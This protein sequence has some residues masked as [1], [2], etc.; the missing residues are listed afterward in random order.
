MSKDAGL[1]ARVFARVLNSALYDADCSQKARELLAAGDVHGAIGEWRR[2][3]ELGSGGARCVLAYLYLRGAPSIPID[4]EEARR[5]CL[6]ALTSEPGYAN[7]LL[8]CLSRMDTET[9]IKVKYLLASYKAGFV[10]AE[11]MMAGIMMASA[12]EPGTRRKKAETMLRRAIDA[13]HVPALIL[14]SSF[15]RAGRLGLVKRVLGILLFPVSQ[16]TYVLTIRFR[17]FSVSSFT[18][19]NE[20][21]RRLFADKFYDR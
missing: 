9:S 5:L 18:Y 16:I 13:G 3:A 15:Y 21:T 4:V 1:S 10:P 20:P 8:G 6:S 2:L 12:N 17:I 19:V 7:Y 14:L 11:T